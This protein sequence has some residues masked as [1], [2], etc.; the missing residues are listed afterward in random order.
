MGVEH[1]HVYIRLLES[2]S[3][4]TIHGMSSLT[5][6]AVMADLPDRAFDVSSCKSDSIQTLLWTSDSNVAVMSLISL[7][8]SH[9]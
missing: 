8:P 2:P 4:G 5:L 9:T 1:T 6:V 7:C 3:P